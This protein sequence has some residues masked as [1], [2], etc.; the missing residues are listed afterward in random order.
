MLSIVK[1]FL[2]NIDRY[3]HPK[4]EIDQLIELAIKL[5]PRLF[6]GIQSSDKSILQLF[7]PYATVQEY[8]EEINRSYICLKSGTIIHLE[9][10]AAK[11]HPVALPMFFL[12]INGFYIHEE[13]AIQVFNQSVL[14]FARLY[15]EKL[16]SEETN[17]G[18][19]RHNLRH[20]TPL[21]NNLYQLYQAF[22]NIV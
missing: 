14:D 1:K 19:D 7:V 10:L 9:T 11:I 3:N 16:D 2:A 15:K 5:D 13:K 6:Q 4:R 21:I 17:T 20:M 18:V 22:N 12:D 8:H